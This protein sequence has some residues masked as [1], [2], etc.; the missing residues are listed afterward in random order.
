MNAEITGTI[1]NIQDAGTDTPLLYIYAM[2]GNVTM[3]YYAVESH[4]YLYCGT[5]PLKEGS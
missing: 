4:F 2:E 3:Q 1:A 5:R